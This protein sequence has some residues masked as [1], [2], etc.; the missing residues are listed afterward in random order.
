MYPNIVRTWKA[1]TYNTAKSVARQTLSGPDRERWDKE[2]YDAISVS[3]RARHSAS[4]ETRTLDSLPSRPFRHGL[5]PCKH[6][7]GLT[8]HQQAVPSFSS[9][10]KVPLGDNERLPCLLEPQSRVDVASLYKTYV[11]YAH[12]DPKAFGWSA[13]GSLARSIRIHT[14]GSLGQ[15]VKKR[16]EV[17]NGVSRTA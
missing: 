15:A 3:R 16:H 2:C 10:F 6:S 4:R 17:Q 13:Q 5:K 14:F 12:A 7:E 9:S 11:A 8:E 1:I